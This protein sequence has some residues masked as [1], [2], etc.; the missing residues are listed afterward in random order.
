MN[1]TFIDYLNLTRIRE[2]KKFLADEKLSIGDIA[3]K[4]GFNDQ[5]YFTKVFKKH[6]GMTP[7]KYR[8]QN[9]FED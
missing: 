5:S 9:F 6:E 8:K 3:V 4:L 1:M 7:G 2:S